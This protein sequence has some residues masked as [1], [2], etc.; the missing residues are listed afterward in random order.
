MIA[1]ITVT[2]SPARFWLAIGNS[3]LS[4][5]TLIHIE[6]SLVPVLLLLLL[7]LARLETT[8]TS[9]GEKVKILMAKL[10]LLRAVF[11][12]PLFLITGWL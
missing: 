9:R 11:S 8:T 3:Y 2:R 4:K 12:S 7:F 1:I 6:Y 10:S 5:N